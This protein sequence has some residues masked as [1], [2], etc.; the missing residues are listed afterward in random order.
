HEGNKVL[1]RVSDILKKIGRRGDVVARYGGEE[2]VALL[3]DSTLEAAAALAESLRERIAGLDLHDVVG[4][5]PIRV[6]IGVA[7]ISPDRLN[8]DALLKASDDAMYE[9]KRL[10]RDRVC[11]SAA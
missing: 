10:G 9:A 4:D 11:L 2:F 6:S 5:I 3:P 7:S 1:E 8:A